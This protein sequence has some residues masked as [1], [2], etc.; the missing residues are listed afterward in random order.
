MADEDITTGSSEQNAPDV[1]VKDNFMWIRDS[2]GFGSVT[3]TFFT[4]AFWV[5]TIAYVLGMFEG[6]IPW[7]NFKLRPFD[8]AAS[9]SYLG[10][11]ASVYTSRKFTEAKYK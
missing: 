11:I 6:T 1:Q 5:T 8:V 2:K 9:A 10:I 4:V 7:V 3:L